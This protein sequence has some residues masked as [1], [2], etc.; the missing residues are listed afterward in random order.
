MV[1]GFLVGVAELH[2]QGVVKGNLPDAKLSH[3]YSPDS[4]VDLGVA[5][6]I[7]NQQSTQVM[8]LYAIL[9]TPHH[10]PI[11]TPSYRQ[12]GH[13]ATIKGLPV[14]VVVVVMR[15]R[16]VGLGPTPLPPVEH[17]M[18]LMRHMHQTT[19]LK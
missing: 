13:A 3:R 5:H 4:A 15:W 14:V 1:G 9:Y 7:K 17:H 10:L 12:A 8:F 18:H 16:S 11:P 6:R 2:A 19:H